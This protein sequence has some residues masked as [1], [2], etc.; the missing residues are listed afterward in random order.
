MKAIGRTENVMALESNLAVDGY[1]EA[2]GRK[3]SKVI[4]TF[5]VIQ[6]SG[7]HWFN[8]KYAI[9]GRYGVRQ[10]TIS[11]A[12]YEG[13]WAN[14]LQDGYGSETYADSGTYQGQWLRGMRHGY[15]VR[16]SAPFGVASSNKLSDNRMNSSTSLNQEADQPA[17]SSSASVGSKRGGGDEPRGGFV[18]RSKSDEAPHRRRSLVERT[19][20]KTFV[21]V[22]FKRV[23]VGFLTNVQPAS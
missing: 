11:N 4:K 23:W 5:V 12:K 1:I 3:G 6:M 17:G 22:R 8:Y 2:S 7:L 19:G 15:G 21:Q 9:P 18:L 13:T 20:M 16:T 10:A 14:G